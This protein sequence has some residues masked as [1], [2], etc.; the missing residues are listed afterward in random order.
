MERQRE[1]VLARGEFE[2]SGEVTFGQLDATFVKVGYGLVHLRVHSSGG[3]EQVI[4]TT[5]EHPVYVLGEGWVATGE[6]KT[7]DRLSDAEGWSEI[8]EVRVESRLEGVEVF[9]LRVT[10][11]HT[12]FVREQGSLATPL[13]VHNA[14]YG[15]SNVSAGVTQP[16]EDLRASGLKDAHHVIQDASVRKLRGYDTNKA[17]GVQLPGP[18]TAAGTPH[19]AATRVQRLRGGGTYA[20]ERRIGYRALRRAGWSEDA[21]RQAIREAD[22]YCAG[23]GVKM[24]T[25]TRVPGNR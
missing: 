22:S 18:S 5:A 9:N 25:I 3:R 16:I 12:Y 17:P 6:L 10:P 4:T 1:E 14:R 20:A 24:G 7:G 19:Y 23:I 13:W 8:R 21:A 2:A 11:Q 15:K